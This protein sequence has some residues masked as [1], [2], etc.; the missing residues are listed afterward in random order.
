MIL[1]EFLD[2]RNTFIH[3]V[4]DVPGWSSETEQGRQMARQFVD[5]LLIVDNTVRDTF[6]A[7]LAV[8]QREVDIKT[9][10]DHMLGDINTHR[11]IVNYTFFE[12]E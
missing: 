1:E 5:R 7:L 8:W 2:K 9:P 12:K 4:A 6:I 10:V 11:K 3:R